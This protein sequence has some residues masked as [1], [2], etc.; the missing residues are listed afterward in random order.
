MRQDPWLCKKFPSLLQAAGLEPGPL[1]LH[2]VVDTTA[3]SY[4][5]K[6]VVLAALSA[7]PASGCASAASPDHKASFAHSSSDCL[8]G[9]GRPSESFSGRI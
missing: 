5:Y 4:G 9:R 7:F 3:D 8:G 6:H 1:N 2:T